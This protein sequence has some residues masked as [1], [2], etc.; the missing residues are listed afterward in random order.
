MFEN[1]D[2]NFWASVATIFSVIF[3]L[4]VFV[5]DSCNQETKIKREY[6]N[7]LISLK[8]ELQKNNDVTLKFFD[9]D[10]S[11]M[12]NTSKLPYYRYTLEVTNRLLAQGLIQDLTLLRNLDAI[13]DSEMQVNRILDSASSVADLSHTISLDETVLYQNRLKSAVAQ[14]SILNESLK[15]YLP[16]VLNELEIHIKETDSIRSPWFCI[17]TNYDKNLPAGMFNK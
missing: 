13:S 5:S 10:F 14:I 15:K 12:S 1:K 3:A 2:I 8:F 4:V 16:L 9:R 11:S 7:S 17:N 6:I